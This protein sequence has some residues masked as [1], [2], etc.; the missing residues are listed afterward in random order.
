MVC[1]IGEQKVLLE[2]LVNVVSVFVHVDICI[3]Q[4]VK[5]ECVVKDAESWIQ[6]MALH[7]HV[8]DCP[9]D[10]QQTQAEGWTKHPT[11]NHL[12]QI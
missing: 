1:H 9:E 5:V 3:A 4:E 2:R 7:L 10:D 11:L 12:I 6:L 8:E